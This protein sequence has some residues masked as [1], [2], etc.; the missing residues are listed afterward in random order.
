MSKI[1]NSSEKMDFQARMSKALKEY[2]SMIEESMSSDKKKSRT[3]LAKF[4]ELKLE[5]AEIEAT[6]FQGKFP[7]YLH[8]R[9]FEELPMAINRKQMMLSPLKVF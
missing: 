1:S 9:S 7:S 5:L 2:N 4:D 6:F 8:N 3:L